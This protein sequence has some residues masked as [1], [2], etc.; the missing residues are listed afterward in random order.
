MPR[1][2]ITSKPL[3]QTPRTVSVH[4]NVKLPDNAEPNAYLEFV[5]NY[6]PSKTPTR[7]VLA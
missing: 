2:T 1:Y 5:T 3:T 4:A 7:M 6:Q